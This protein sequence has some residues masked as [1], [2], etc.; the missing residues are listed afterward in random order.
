MTIR[1]RYWE[2][3]QIGEE[4]P[5]MRFPLS[6][7]RLV[8]AAGANRDFN[9]IHHNS[10]YAQETGAPDMYANIIF[11]LGMWEKAAREFIG[12]SGTIRSVKDFRMKIFNTVGD[13]VVVKGYV[14]SKWQEGNESFV[15]IRIWSENSKGISVGPGQVVITLPTKAGLSDKSHEFW[16]GFSSPIPE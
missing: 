15:S 7:A 3:V 6:I 9:S 5:A 12:L 11:L 10:A 4:I 8:M 14:S 1:Q 13:T 16:P 2:D